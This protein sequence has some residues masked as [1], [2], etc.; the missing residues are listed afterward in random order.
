MSLY[1]IRAKY[2]APNVNT[3]L[4]MCSLQSARLH[5]ELVVRTCVLILLI[6]CALCQFEIFNMGHLCRCEFADLVC[7]SSSVLVCIVLLVLLRLR[8]RTASGVISF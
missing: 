3:L 2:C 5:V 6:G 7:A 1:W 4:H 8:T